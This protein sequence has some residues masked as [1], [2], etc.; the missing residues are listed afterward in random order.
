MYWKPAKTLGLV[1]GLAILCTIGAVAY[2]LLHSVLSQGPGV[3]AFVTGLLLVICVPLLVLWAVW[4]VGLVALRYYM[5]DEVL[6]IHAGLLRHI[7]PLA[8]IQAVELA[9]DLSIDESFRGVGW[10]GYLRGS[11]QV[12]GLGTLIVNSTEPLERQL[13][14]LTGRGCYG[15][16]PR[17]T[18]GFVR[19]LMARCRN[20]TESVGVTPGVAYSP[21]AALPVWRDHA[22]WAIIVGALLANLVL[23]GMV[24]L[25]FSTLPDRLPLFLGPHGEVQHIAAKIALYG[26]PVAGMLMLSINS[27]LAVALHR[28]ERVA[29]YLLALA[30]FG[31][32]AP[33][34]AATLGILQRG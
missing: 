12:E 28:W 10:P 19:D 9:S 22:L 13:V 17:D 21:L 25:R 26:I 29:A 1:V 5:D 15:I 33:L 31:V 30:S 32:H 2:S 11:A 27:V 7:I 14:V 34:W 24:S 16:S 8:A 20:A 23:F 3:N 4:Y 18:E 6:V